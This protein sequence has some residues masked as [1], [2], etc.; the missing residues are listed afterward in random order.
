MSL[1]LSPRV[2]RTELLACSSPS[3]SVP[4]PLSSMGPSPRTPL[5]CAGSL[6]ECTG[7]HIRAGSRCVVEWGGPGEPGMTLPL[8]S[9]EPTCC[10]L[11]GQTGIATACLRTTVV[12]S[13]SSFL[14][15]EAAGR[16][17]P[18]GRRGALP[19]P[20]PPARRAARLVGGQ[21]DMASLC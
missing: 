15:G 3:A 18:R 5:R 9:T 11:L 6:S 10:C 12:L 16:S 14:N 8:P 21:G 7:K 17:G 19:S 2:A 4:S 13:W 20:Q 1:T